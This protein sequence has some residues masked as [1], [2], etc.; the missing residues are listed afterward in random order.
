MSIEIT[1]QAAAPVKP[2]EDNGKKTV[3][4]F[5][6]DDPGSPGTTVL[7]SI[8]SDDQEGDYK[9][10][11]GIDGDQGVPGPAGPPGTIAVQFVV[12]ANN[13]TELEV[14][15]LLGI[16]SEVV[17]HQKVGA[18]GTDLVTA[19]FYDESGPVKNAPFV[20]NTGDG[21][22]TRWVAQVSKFTNIGS[23]AADGSRFITVAEAAAIAAI[24]PPTKQKYF[25]VFSD[26]ASQD[27]YGV[28]SAGSTAQTFFT[29]QIPHDFVSLISLQAVYFNSSSLVTVDI[30]LNSNY[31]AL[32]E[33]RANHQE[34]DTTTTYSSNANEISSLDISVVFSSLAA[35]DFCGVNVDHN[36]IG[37]TSKYLGILLRYN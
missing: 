34:S 13:P 7:G 32:G 16:G 23:V 21:G 4:V 36:G 10:P 3:I 37:A 24:V 2:R 18:N 28:R 25:S 22:D 17:A 27:N 33:D 35:G 20:M 31:G 14:L 1:Q 15:T 8:D 29:F 6:K 9:G 26:T 5:A 19:Y 30:D 11:K 12:D